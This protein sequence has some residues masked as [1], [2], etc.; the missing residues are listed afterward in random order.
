VKIAVYGYVWELYNLARADEL[1]RL[2]GAQPP[3][4]ERRPP[5]VGI[6][7]HRRVRM[8]GHRR[9]RSRR[10]APRRT[11][12]LRQDPTNALGCVTMKEH[13]G[14]ALGQ[15]DAEPQLRRF[16]TSESLARVPNAK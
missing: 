7:P 8:G 12:C 1:W 11:P 6:D 16:C 14:T 13:P 2:N 5:S 15:Q 4:S 9:G 3:H 10:L